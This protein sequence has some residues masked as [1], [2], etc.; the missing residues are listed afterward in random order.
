[1]LVH[2]SAKA[3]M[4]NGSCKWIWVIF[5]IDE[6]LIILIRQG[7]FFRKFLRQ[8]RARAIRVLVASRLAKA[9][10]QAIAD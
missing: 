10:T 5:C 1:M 9:R 7:A 8:E 6:L 3:F 4:L 2:H